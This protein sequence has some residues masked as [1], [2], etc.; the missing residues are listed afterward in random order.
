M[1]RS[2]LSLLALTLIFLFSLT[3]IGC[4]ENILVNA[5]LDPNHN[6]AGIYYDSFTIL[7]K[8]VYDDSINT[9]YIP[10]GLNIYQ[11]VGVINNNADPYFGQ[12]VAGT[13]FQLVPTVFGVDF[14]NTYKIDSAFIILPYSGLTWGDTT[15]PNATQHFVAYMAK[16]TLS[17]A[18]NYLPSRTPNIYSDTIGGITVN[19]NS[20]KNDSLYVDGANHPSCL[21]IPL[22]S[23]FINKLANATNTDNTSFI[24]AIPGVYVIADSI[25]GGKALTYF[26]LT[27]DGSGSMYA[28][29]GIVV[30]CKQSGLS[31]DTV[32]S[33]Y[34]NNSACAHYN[35][36]TRNY[37]G[38][39]YV[40]N[41]LNSTALSDSVLLLQNQPGLAIDLKICNITHLI[42]AD[43]KIPLVNQAQLCLPVKG[44]GN[45]A[46]DNLFYLP[47]LLHIRGIIAPSYNPDSTYTI[48]DLYPIGSASALGL[49]DGSQ[50]NLNNINTYVLNIPREIQNAL[51]NHK[52]T[53]H[54]RI[55][56]TREFYGAYRTVI[57]GAN[58]NDPNYRLKLKVVYS[59]LN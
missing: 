45:T 22:D 58:N 54:V 18:N 53:V 31:T 51:I 44:T 28:H 57:G 47:N 16:D 29:A 6:S 49:V 59:K 33:F 7:S 41:L 42:K 55:N 19:I 27:D 15:D 50:K 35:T 25:K 3:Q 32:F 11:A 43:G 8:T 26:R 21:R 39:N 24:N 52:D 17:I 46:L 38:I 56:G 48:A 12:T 30:Y 5:K 37:A 4:R 36:V 1:K 10:S 23:A 9:S 34:H 13:Q 2:S 14:L 20:L 40:Q